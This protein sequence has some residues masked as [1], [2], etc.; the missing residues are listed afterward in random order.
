MKFLLY[1]LVGGLVMLASVV[2]LYVV[3]AD[4]RRPV[5]PALATSQSLDIDPDTERWLFVGF[6]VA[7]AI[8]APMFPVHTW[9]PDT[10]EQATPGTSVLLVC[11][12]DKIGTFGMLRFCL[13]LFP[14]ASQW[15]TP[16][17]LVLALISHRVRRARGD[18]PG[19][20]PAA[21]RLHLG[22]ATSASS[23]SASSCS[24]ARARPAR[25]LYMFNHGLVDRR[26]VP[27]RRLPDQPPRLGADPR[28]SAAS[29]RS[30]RCS[31]GCSWSPACRRSSLPGPVAVRLRDPGADRGVRRTTGGRRRSRSLGIVLAALYILLMYQRTMTGPVRD[32]DR[33]HARTSSAA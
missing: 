5:V 31:P 16:V 18:R 27:G 4:A 20:H 30:R 6:F 22:V 32:R 21:D 15:A 23:C 24:T 17:V 3:S 14:E 19:R 29:R 10:T 26:A 11:I 7:F 2:G 13:G 25:S 9:L 12:L 33:R 8:K 28:L 1:Q